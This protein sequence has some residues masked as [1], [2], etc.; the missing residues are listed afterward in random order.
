MT[1][2]PS[3]W[4]A[5]GAVKPIVEKIQS[6]GVPNPLLPKDTTFLIRLST[7][8]KAY[9]V[10]AAAKYNMPLSEFMR[11]SVNDVCQHGLGRPQLEP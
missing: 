11:L 6:G 10:K 9:W 3:K 8:E 5:H 4:T 7:A 1:W 2:D